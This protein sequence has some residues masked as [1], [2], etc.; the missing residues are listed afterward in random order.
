MSFS[1][2]EAWCKSLGGHLPI[3][4]NQDENELLP[5]GNVWLG[6]T[7]NETQNFSYTNWAENEP[8]NMNPVCIR[9]GKLWST[10][11]ENAKKA[12]TCYLSISGEI[13]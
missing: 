13:L 10:T 9:Y 1:A 8:R 3:P 2:A 12:A 7:V 11:K 5:G 6:L 4:R